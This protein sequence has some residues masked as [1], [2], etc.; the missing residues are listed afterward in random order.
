MRSQ[1][2]DVLFQST[3]P[4]WGETASAF[5][6]SVAWRFQ[7]TPPVWGETGFTADGVGLFPFQSTPPVWGETWPSM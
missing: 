6:L 2:I 4:V 3:P 1:M 5:S 7:S